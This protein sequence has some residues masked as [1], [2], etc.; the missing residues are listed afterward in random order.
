MNEG[1]T[2]WQAFFDSHAP[3]YDENPFT[4]NT[5]VEVDFLFEVMGLQPGMSV[6]DVGCGTGRHSV[7]LAARGLEV[8]G[9]DISEGM[10]DQARARAQASGVEVEWV[11]ADATRY[12]HPRSLDAAICL[13]EGAINLVGHDEDPVAHDLAI[14]RNIGAALQPGA[15]F[16]L[17]AMNGYAPI[18]R[19]TDE[20][21]AAGQFDPATMLSRYDDEWDL[22]EGTV[23]M[24]IRERLFIPP[25]ISAMLHH[26]GFEVLH[27]WGGTAGDWGKRAL[28]LDEIEVMFVC[29]RRLD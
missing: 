24:T 21:V 2:F 17:T 27:I 6:L 26:A 4:K 15:P 5:R 7:E 20:S 22:P 11:H 19:M 10:L 8:V 28:K 12:R 18:R 29:R 14:L 16:V 9:V 25:E 1:K 23:R 13:C 3:H